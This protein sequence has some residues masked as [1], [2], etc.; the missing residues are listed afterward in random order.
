MT[1]IRG[2]SL[3]GFPELVGELGGDS[4]GLLRR[5]RIP[6]SAVADYESF[7]DYVGLLRLLE[8]A[9]RQ[10]GV[11]DFGLRLAGRQGIEI[12][13]T[14][15][16]AA[17]S[18]PTV[19]GALAIF[20]RFLR[21]YSP[22]LEVRVSTEPGRQ[23]ATYEFRI[24]LDHLPPHPQGTELALGVSLNVFRLLLGERWSPV[25]V[26]IPHERLSPRRDYFA[27]FGAP[28]TFA[29]SISGFQVK[30]AELAGPLS[31]DRSVH[32]VLL[33]HLESSTPML[34]SGVSEAVGQLVRRLLPTGVLDL[35]LVAAQLALHPRT[36]QRRLAEEGTSFA[37]VVDQTRRR[38]AET[39]LRDTDMGLGH[40]AHELGYT[41]QSVLTRASRRWFGTSPLAYR[42][43]ARLSSPRT[44]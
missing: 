5:H 41:E 13:G 14:V 6:Q 9:A 23:L 3:S 36:L 8:D 27:Y 30:A 32:E 20:E 39:Y 38:T 42:K 31:G 29:D 2:T 33:A 4:L 25:R 11:A 26:H 7:V 16:A 24:I 43:Q 17:L 34:R 10:T 18:A 22:A 1:Q 35:E 21:A 40:L 19:S 15:G 12:L 28:V 44:T 37:S